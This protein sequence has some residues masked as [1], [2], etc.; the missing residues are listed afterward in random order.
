[1]RSFFLL[2][3]L[4]AVFPVFSRAQEVKLKDESVTFS[5]GSH[6]AIVAEIPF[7]KRAIVEKQLKS[8]LKG[9]GGKLLISGDEYKV[10]QGKMKVFGDKRFDGYA[11]IIETA[12]AIKVA[13]A[14]DMG[15][16]F[17]S[18][19]D[20]PSEYKTIRERV[21]NF[22]AKTGGLSLDADLDADKKALKVLEKEEKQIEKSIESSNKDIESYQKKIKQAEKDIE[23]KKAELS[24]KQEEIKTQN[25]QIT[26]RK[27]TAKKIK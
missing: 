11:K 18:A 8:E 7:G 6:H 27:K 9:W 15:G 20:H 17:M 25:L 24:I 5:V 16:K 1:M 26:E 14:V 2:I 10:V 4:T 13:F 22:G 19:G 21:R 23:A 12:D 3:G